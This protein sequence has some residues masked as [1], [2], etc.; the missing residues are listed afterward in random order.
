MSAEAASPSYTA[1]FQRVLF[2]IFRPVLFKANVLA[3]YII[4]HHCI[5]FIYAMYLYIES[6]FNHKIYVYVYIYDIKYDMLRFT[7]CMLYCFVLIYDV[8]DVQTQVVGPSSCAP[9]FVGRP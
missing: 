2:L 5:H 8:F 7:Y 6:A 1:L 3:D 9:V 4:L